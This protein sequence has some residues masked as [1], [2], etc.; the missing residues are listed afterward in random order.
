[1]AFLT[2][3]R[4]METATTTGTGSFTL[5]GAVAGFRAFSSV[6]S[7]NDTFPYTIEA[8]DGSNVPTGDWECGIGTYSGSNT[9]ARTT[10]LSSSN[11]NAAVSFSAG[12]KRCFIGMQDRFSGLKLIGS[13]T[14]SSAVANITFSG[15]PRDYNTLVV[16]IL[17]LG[18]D[19]VTAA[20]TLSYT[21]SPDGST[22]ATARAVGATSLAHNDAT[23]FYGSLVFPGI[24]Q[25]SGLVVEG[26]FSGNSPSSTGSA[27]NVRARRCDGGITAVRLVPTTSGNWDS[28]TVNLWGA[29]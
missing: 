26:L 12:T 22:Y 7:T 24:Q 16:D 21:F 17:G 8:V 10:V 28:G 23:G 27:G 14:V 3:D 25:S 5:A 20:Q 4:V 29:R 2:S 6:C 18:H 11:S 9:L 13:V 1:M 15:I 19:Y